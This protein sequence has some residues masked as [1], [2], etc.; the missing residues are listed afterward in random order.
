MK[1]TLDYIEKNNLLLFKT[2]SG[3]HAY[4]TNIPTSDTDIR[5][6]F[7]C[8][9]DDFLSG[10]YPEQI[11]DNKNDIVYYELS[12][13]LNLL[14][15]ANPNILE[16]LNVPEECLL[17][18]HPLFDE[19]LN[20]KEKFITKNCRQSFGGYAVSQIKKARG[21]NKKQNW[22]KERIQK[23]DIFDFCYII[24]GM[25]SIPL[26]KWLDTNNIDQ[27]YCGLVEVPNTRDTFALYYDQNGEYK[28]NGIGK[29]GENNDVVSNQ[30]RVSSVPKDLDAIAILSYNK[31]SYTMH[32]VDYQSYETW[33][34]NR[35]TSRY[36]QTQ[37]DGNRIDSK[38]MMHC[39]RL[40]DMCVEMAEGKGIIVKRPNANYYLDIRN[41][42]L[43]LDELIDIAE[44]KII[45]ID[46]LFEKSNLPD[47]VE[48]NLIN[49]LTIKIRKEF[50]NVKY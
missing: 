42:K 33:L 3:S 24:D 11:N 15:T 44:K 13:F 5:G 37:S 28:F 50:Y 32:C 16:L 40:L 2:I 35:N 43:N 18:K 7:I 9:F 34:E 4:G 36:I 12:K 10:N 1:Y 30:L 19:I 45:E 38:N 41:G 14:N 49:K 46:E 31:D 27:K 22:E 23:K 39:M 20:N 17:F 29:V 6:V 8:E 48:K 21:L 26:K 47:E 25:R